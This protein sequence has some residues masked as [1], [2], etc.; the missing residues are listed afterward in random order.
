MKVGRLIPALCVYFSCGAPLFAQHAAY[1]YGRILDP[2]DAA[3]AGTAVTV[4][5]EDTGFRRVTQSEPDGAYLVSSLLPGI[6]KITVRKDGFCTMIRFHVNVTASRPARADFKLSL[7]SVQETITVEGA[8]PLLDQSDASVETKV[9]RRQIERLPLNGRGL[10]TLLEMAPGTNVTPATRGEAG[11][12]T[13][14]GQRPNANYFTVDG[15]SANTGVSAGGAPAQTTGGALPGMSAFGSLDALIPMEAVEEFQVQTS[16]SPSSFGRLPGAMVSLTSRSGTDEFHGE[17]LYRFRNESTAANDWFANF[18]GNGRAPERMLDFS[19]TLGGP[20][21]RNRTFFFLSYER[22]SLRQ[23]YSWQQTVPSADVRESAPASLQPALN[24]FPL[25]N[26]PELGNGLAQWTAHDTRPSLLNSGSLR[27]DQAVTSRLTLFGRYNN[28]PSSNEFGSNQVN[29][30][31]LRAW[32]LTAGAS[33]RATAA[34][35]LDVRV[36]E[37]QSSLHSVW[38]ASGASGFAACS[39]QPLLTYYLNAA[40][41]CD[42]LVRFSIGGVGQEV[43]GREGDRR[44]RQFEI[45]PS[46]SWKHGPHNAQFGADYRRLR[47]IRRD[48]SGMLGII[49]D[50]ISA[51]ADPRNLWVARTPADNGT[52][53]VQEAAIW[54]HDSWQAAPGLTLNAGLR[55]EFNP[56]PGLDEPVFFLNPLSN[57][58]FADKLP[59]WRQPYGSLAPRLGAAYRIGRTGRTVLRG[60][61]G[62]YYDSSLSI[63]TDVINGGPLNVSQFVSERSAP[64]SMLLSY[65]FKPKL[66]LPQVKQWNVSVEHALSAHD[67]VSAGYVG[68]AGRDLIRR[69]I[70]GA[71]SSPVAWVALTTDHGASDFQ[72]LQAQYRR[73]LARGVE[74]LVSYAWSHSLDNDSSDLSLMWAGSGLTPAS[75]HASSDFDVRH[76]FTAALTWDIPHPGG[77]AGGWLDGWALDGVFHARSGFPISV[78]DSDEYT[79]VGL[80]NAFRPNVVPGQPIWIADPAEPGGRMLNTA[81]FQS[82]PGGVQG[83]LGRNAITGFGMSQL[84]LALGRQF[85]LGERRSLHLRIEAFNALNH[86]NFADPV[87]FRNSALFGQ[88]TSMLNLMLGTGSPAS[89]LAPMLQSGGPRSVEAVLRFQF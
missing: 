51:V 27:I 48:A 34:S 50:D 4:V 33:L 58:M 41:P 14:G 16:T 19:Q 8:A 43:S 56:P 31:D 82:A 32:S 1:L 85:R 88:S 3:V 25:P 21:R 72:S 76:S 45:L 23:P 12:F 54:A 15:M 64:F 81:A 29:R 74:A 5:N 86:A 38:T 6:Y 40:T 78:L 46:A 53:S 73:S 36:N 2:S 75:D 20:V 59:L 49:A 28:A 68:S 30:L 62:L 60:G 52:V 39:V 9:S 61:V 71:G 65:G 83:N 37:S 70:G 42:Y 87:K 11:Q 55:W 24:L 7:G 17:S 77:R 66:R 89:G 47:P 10:L 18:S 26:G 80:A 67:V 84:D 63:A 79:G 69:E 35:V 44:Q 13:T 22:V 57:T